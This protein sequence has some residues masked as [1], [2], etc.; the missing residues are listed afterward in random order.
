MNPGQLSSHQFIRV[1]TL[2]SVLHQ[3]TNRKRR[4]PLTPSKLEEPIG[5]RHRFASKLR[6]VTSPR[7]PNSAVHRSR[8]KQRGSR[9]KPEVATVSPPGGIWGWPAYED[10]DRT[11]AIKRW[12]IPQD[13]DAE[14]E[15]TSI[16][17]IPL[18][19]NITLSISR[20]TLSIR[21]PLFQ[22]KPSSAR[23][24]FF[25]FLAVQ[26]RSFLEPRYSKQISA[27]LNITKFSFYNFTSKSDKYFNKIFEVH[28]G[29]ITQNV[30]KWSCV[31]L[32]VI[33][34]FCANVLIT[35]DFPV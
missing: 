23:I 32:Y 17:R 20:S 5:G 12:G 27:W 1:I 8:V 13:V 19:S 6:T 24:S 15:R 28:S 34:P 29:T 11:R 25:L 2:L 14:R 21:D 7:T 4:N 3:I 26:Y 10:R 16:S 22:I 30:H 31:R 33:K 18:K 9:G 35:N